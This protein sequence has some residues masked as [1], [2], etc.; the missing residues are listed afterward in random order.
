MIYIYNAAD[1]SKST[2]FKS[3]WNIYR[4]LVRGKHV[5]T[6]CH[7]MCKTYLSILSYIPMQHESHVSTNNLNLK[8]VWHLNRRA[9]FVN[10]R[11]TYIHSCS[12]LRRE[13]K[14]EIAR[15]NLPTTSIDLQNFQQ[16]ESTAGLITQ[17]T[18]HLWSYSHPC[19]SDSLYQCFYWENRD[20][21][22]RHLPFRKFAGFRYQILGRIQAV[23]P[24]FFHPHRLEFS[25]KVRKKEA[26]VASRAAKAKQRSV[27]RGLC[28]DAV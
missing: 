12:S 22:F 3:T 15:L 28:N 2:T 16:M 25:W 8:R 26:E 5:H 20:Q 11:K 18:L 13:E 9:R 23:Q 10:Y 7:V 6:N 19:I 1:A 21:D 4:R 24:T 14:L 17:S 27:K